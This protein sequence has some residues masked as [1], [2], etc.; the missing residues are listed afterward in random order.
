MTFH[1]NDEGSQTDV[2]IL[3]FSKAFD[4]IPRKELV[5]IRELWHNWTPSSL[6]SDIPYPKRF[7]HV[8]VDGEAFAKVLLD[9]GYPKGLYWGP[10]FSYAI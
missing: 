7:M 10:C 3:D 8:V 2:I 1:Y 6:A 5:E 4:T 9:S